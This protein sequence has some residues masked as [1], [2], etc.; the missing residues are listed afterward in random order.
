MLVILKTASIL[1]NFSLSPFL[2]ETWKL[3]FC[4]LVLHWWRIVRIGPSFWEILTSLQ[5]AWRIWCCP[6]SMTDRKVWRQ[7]LEMSF[8][9]RGTVIMRNTWE[10]M[11]KWNLARQPNNSSC[12]VF[13]L[14]QGESEAFKL[15]S[16]L[17]SLGL[18]VVFL[19]VF[20]LTLWMS[21]SDLIRY[22]TTSKIPLHAEE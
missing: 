19:V 11:S 1:C 16:L 5:T 20:D 14:I 12:F 18:A 9:G 8:P 10:G 15:E 7:L 2:T 13:T 22:S 3:L 21:F 17:Y 4:V 6:S